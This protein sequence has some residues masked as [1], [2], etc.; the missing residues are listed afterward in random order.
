MNG[1][2]TAFSQAAALS[3]KVGGGAW[4]L[5]LRGRWIGV[6]LTWLLMLLMTVPDNFDYSSLNT[7]APP[8]AGSAMS[9][10]LWLGLLAAPAAII[11]WRTALTWLMLRWVNL[12]LLAFCAL[13][14]F[15]ATWS[16]APGV[17]IRRFIRVA[18]V[19]LCALSFVV[20][21]WDARRFQRVLLPALTLLLGGSLLFGLLRPQLGIHQETSPELLHAWRGLTNNKNS[22]GDCASMGVILWLHAW[23][24]RES[25]RWK[26]LAGIAI[27]GACLLLSRSSTALMVTVMVSGLLLLLCRAPLRWRPALPPLIVTGLLI[28]VFYSLVVLKL[29][30]GLDFLLKPVMLLT[31]KNMTFTGRTDIWAIVVD[32]AR[33]HFWLGTGYGAYWIGPLPWAPVYRVVALLNFYPGSAHSG[34]LEIFNDLGLAGLACLL[35]FMALFMRDALRLLRFD[36]A[37]GALMIALFAQQVMGNLSE[38]HWFSVL[39]SDFV[40][41]S[42]ATLCLARQLLDQQLRRVFGEPRFSAAQP[43]ADEPHSM[44]AVAVP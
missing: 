31:G 21:G 12:G 38:T 40:I 5:D 19:L 13:A 39:S 14:I 35:G 42:F 10:L 4:A 3:P 36:H 1:V 17:T 34:Y 15:S 9:R 11:A 23:L 28:T 22:L 2:A 18:A 43:P 6:A 41:M 27:A 29:V 44:T 37:Q 8:E 7:G 20:L 33:M 24:S 16:D 25:G 30:P 26:A 32:H